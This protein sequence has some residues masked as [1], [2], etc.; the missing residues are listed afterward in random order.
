M[1][2]IIIIAAALFIGISS[3]AA[4]KDNNTKIQDFFNKQGELIGSTSKVDF[5]KLP[6]DAI[7]T[8]T[9]KYTFPTY[10]LKEC[11]AFVDV[12]GDVTYYVSM[13]SAKDKLVLN[14]STEGEVSVASRI[15]K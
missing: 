7:Q 13:T 10:T 9:T 1:K 6:Q 2:K 4:S 12:Y 8:I 11:I 3:F 5:D 14:I 15:K